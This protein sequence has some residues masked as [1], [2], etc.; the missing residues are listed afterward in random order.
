MSDVRLPTRD[1]DIYLGNKIITPIAP[2]ACNPDPVK[3]I[4]LAKKNF[5]Q[6]MNPLK[7]AG[8]KTIMDLMMMLPFGL[9]NP[10]FYLLSVKNT[11]I[12]TSLPSNFELNLH[13]G[14]QIEGGNLITCARENRSHWQSH[15][16]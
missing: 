3:N 10:A 2:L 14:I 5:M 15:G 9:S 11:C 8:Y 1:E 16:T 13:G 6:E 7:M 12:I 4:E